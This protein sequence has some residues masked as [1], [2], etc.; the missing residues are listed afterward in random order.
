MDKSAAGLNVSSVNINELLEQILKRLQPIADKQKV[1][2]V[3]EEFPPGY[4]RSG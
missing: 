1:E 2:L 4:R 3:L